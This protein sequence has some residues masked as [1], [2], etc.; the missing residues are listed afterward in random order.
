M[1]RVADMTARWALAASVL[2]QA[3]IT[4][5]LGWSLNEADSLLILV[6]AA[7]TCMVCGAL[8]SRPKD[9]G[10]VWRRPTT[11]RLISLNVWTAVSFIS[12]FIGVAVHSAAVVLTLEASAAP[13]ALIVW[14]ALGTHRADQRPH[15]GPA[16]CATAFV[17]A[18]VGMLLVVVVAQSDPAR[19]SALLVASVLAV[20]AAVAA[21]RVASISRE[22]GQHG[23]GVAQVMAHRFYLTTAVAVSALLALVPQ[24][25][26]APPVLH[27]SLIGA[28]ALATVVVPM[29]LLQ[30]SMQRL[31]PLAV[32]AALAAAPAI[33]IAVDLASG[34][35]VSWL[36]LMLGALLVPGNLALMLARGH[37]LKPL[38]RQ[39]L[40]PEMEYQ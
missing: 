5:A 26:L 27:A 39:T 29:Y 20:L 24:G 14:T 23:V 1:E 6:F 18:V 21:G 25:V 19:T 3:A 7:L 37:P 31:E 16:Q 35:S 12:F 38:A 15:P 30:Y 4:A 9:G 2:L 40:Q 8:T 11:A 34:Q 17:L 33:A 32:T 22:L 36:V 13:L 10:R 28:G